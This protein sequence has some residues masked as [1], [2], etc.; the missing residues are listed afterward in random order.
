MQENASRKP[1]KLWSG[2]ELA[3]P[4]SSA[5]P[6]AYPSTIRD[7]LHPKTL[8]S[9]LPDPST[10]QETRMPC[11]GGKA[12][13]QSKEGSTEWNPRWNTWPLP[14]S[15]SQDT[16]VVKNQQKQPISHILIRAAQTVTDQVTDSEWHLPWNSRNTAQVLFFL[17]VQS[18]RYF[19]FLHDISTEDTHLWPESR[20]FPPPV[21][22]VLTFLL[23]VVWAITF[24]KLLR[25]A[26]RTQWHHP[27]GPRQG[28]NSL[29]HIV[30]NYLDPTLHSISLTLTSG[31]GPVHGPPAPV[32]MCG[33]SPVASPKYSGFSSLR[34]PGTFWPG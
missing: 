29:C 25:A 1:G 5:Q 12:P 2:P 7:G 26:F 4:I 32:G 22:A 28:V 17:Q 20:L 18:R 11:N 3:P 16:H 34:R 33:L 8:P 15:L 6:T 21:S 9:P 31:S 19:L 24:P 27:P 30:K 13:S 23:H 10:T 14:H